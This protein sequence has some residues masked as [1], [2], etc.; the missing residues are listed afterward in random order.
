MSTQTLEQDEQVAPSSRPPVPRAQPRR[1]PVVVLAATVLALVLIGIAVVAVRDLLV[2]QG[3]AT[4]S[5]IAPALVD[6][7]DG[8]R[9]TVGLAIGGAVVALAGL[10]LI[11]LGLRP[12]RRT[13]LRVRGDADLWLA[14]GAVAALAQETADRLPG[15][16]SADSSRS[17]RRRTVVDIVVAERSTPDGPQGAAAVAEHVR[18]VLD[19]EV[20]RL[21]G[22]S[23]KVRATE[24]PR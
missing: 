11:W 23:I 15:V 7:S 16:M 9:A 21:T 19:E 17:T 6:G 20:G 5:P 3:W 14:P 1:T 18:A 24:V 4:G 8:L 12:G 22:A 2:S 13:H 10:V